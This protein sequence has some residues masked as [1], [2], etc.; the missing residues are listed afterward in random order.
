MIL[1]RPIEL[2][3]KIDGRITRSDIV[4]TYIPEEQCTYFRLTVRDNGNQG[5][6]ADNYFESHKDKIL[7]LIEAALLNNGVDLPSVY[8]Y[9]G[10]IFSD[11]YAKIAD[12]S[13]KMI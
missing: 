1:Y 2:M 11:F 8:R 12:G 9:H 5:L 3:H 4:F 7:L 13:R 6:L 10:T